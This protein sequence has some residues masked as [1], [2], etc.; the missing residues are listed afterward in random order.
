MRKG[1]KEVPRRRF[2]EICGVTVGSAVVVGLSGLAGCSGDSGE[3][4]QK[5][6]ESD[7]IRVTLDR[8]P[9]GGRLEV[10]IAGVPVELFRTGE[11]VTARSLRCTHFGCTVAWRPE[12]EEYVCPCHDGAF[13]PDGTVAYGPPDDPL[14]TLRVEREGDSVKVWPLEQNAAGP[15]GEE[16]DRT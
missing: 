14:P 3:G 4:G 16:G 6:P 8:L 11:E 12:R 13:G 15:S 5:G 2:L 9:P 7:A 10:E 1:E